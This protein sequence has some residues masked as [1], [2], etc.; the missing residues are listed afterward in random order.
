MARN[1]RAGWGFW[2]KTPEGR[3]VHINGNRNMEQETLDA[4]LRMMDILYKQAEAKAAAKEVD[5][6]NCKGD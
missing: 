4:L 3:T 6:E 2:A 1:K 5:S